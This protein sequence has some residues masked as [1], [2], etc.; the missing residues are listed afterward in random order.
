[1]NDQKYRW[2][3][4]EKIPED[5]ALS[6]I[7]QFPFPL[8]SPALRRIWMELLAL[9]LQRA[10]VAEE[11][12]LI[13]ETMVMGNVDRFSSKFSTENSVSSMKYL[14]T[15]WRQL[16]EL[17]ELFQVSSSH[18]EKKRRW[19]AS[20]SQ[21]SWV[22]RICWARFK[23]VSRVNA[24]ALVGGSSEGTSHLTSRYTS[25]SFSFTPASCRTFLHSRITLNGPGLTR[26]VSGDITPTAFDMLASGRSELL[27]ICLI[28]FTADSNCWYST[29]ALLLQ[30]EHCLS[31][32]V[33]ILSCHLWKHKRQMYS[34]RNSIPLLG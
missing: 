5:S 7:N 11:V 1:M 4:G 17:L 12:W 8:F 27:M 30:R 16:P 25:S 29:T 21:F 33:S 22:P 10:R 2:H 28:S 15:I 9:F 14:E 31:F 18:L 26:L 32:A 34:I 23:F 20:R 19:T 6:T 13:I 24:G 3:L